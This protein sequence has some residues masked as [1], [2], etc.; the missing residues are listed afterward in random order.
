MLN[1]HLLPDHPSPPCIIVYAG[2]LADEYP[3][4]CRFST[5]VY[6]SEDNDVVTS[7]YNVMLA[8][9]ELIEH[10]D[11]VFPLDNTALFAFAQRESV[12]RPR[13][14]NEEANAA[15]AAK[16]KGSKDRGFDAIN[17]VAARMLCHLTSSSR[18][19]GEMNVD[20][21]EIYTNLVPFPRLHFLVTALSIQQRRAEKGGSQLMSAS[22]RTNSMTHGSASAKSSATTG[23]GAVAVGGRHG[24][25]A[26]LQRAFGDVLSERGQIAAAIPTA[27]I[28]HAMNISC[29]SSTPQQQ[30]QQVS[31]VHSHITLSSAFLARGRADSLPL[32]DFLDCVTTAQRSLN[33]PTWNRNAC[34]IGMCGTPSPGEDMSVLA[35]YNST[36]FG[37]V[38]TR[39][40]KGFQR[41]FRKKAMLHHYTEFV[42]VGH[43]YSRDSIIIIIIMFLYSLTN[44]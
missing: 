1:D 14:S 16:G 21:N 10:A 4:I 36:A 5:C 8:T 22:Q 23:A 20:L 44:N 9:R 43:A 25:R 12:G 34:K 15:A 30:Q 24:A 7:P 33:W 35:V 29:S 40:M 28:S 27:N 37:T 13:P 31:G 42:E 3:K 2:L 38:L 19:S 18:F 26:A 6:P 32:T 11:C 41:L 39:E 17:N